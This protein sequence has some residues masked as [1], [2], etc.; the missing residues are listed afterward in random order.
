MPL[1]PQDS[2]PQAG[3]SE[4]DPRVVRDTGVLQTE[5]LHWDSH[6]GD[7]HPCGSESAAHRALCQ[8]RAGSQ[9]QLLPVWLGGGSWG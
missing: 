5:H 2:K 3:A 4:A 9:L 1:L 6:A 8:P 7:S